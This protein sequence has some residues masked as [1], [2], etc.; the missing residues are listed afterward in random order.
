[1]STRKPLARFLPDDEATER[2]GAT[3][4]PALKPGDVIALQGDLGMGKSALARAIIRTLADDLSLEVPSPTFILVQSYALNL[5]VHH[6]DL[7]RLSDE[8]ELEEL[9]LAEAMTNGLVLI[10]WPERAPDVFD[11]AIHITLREEG[12]GR[13]AE[14]AVPHQAYARIAEA[15][16]ASG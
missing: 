3:L 8:S 6:F 10:E 15:L 13:L 11:K 7:Y 16:A 4:A 5:P 14:I 2:L 12:D 9:G 1:M